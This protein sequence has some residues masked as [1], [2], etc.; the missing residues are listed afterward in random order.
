M[1]ATLNALRLSL[2]HDIEV[3]IVG[4]GWFPGGELISSRGVLSI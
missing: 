4:D 1:I 2:K 3:D